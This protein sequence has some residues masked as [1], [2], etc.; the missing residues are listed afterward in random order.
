MCLA[1][2][3]SRLLKG[4]VPATATST[5]ST[6]QSSLA[7]QGEDEDLRYAAIAILTINECLPA[8]PKTNKAGTL[9][10]SGLLLRF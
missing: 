2:V 10:G 5:I 7:N 3:E 8:F 4:E 6:R 9:S 1:G